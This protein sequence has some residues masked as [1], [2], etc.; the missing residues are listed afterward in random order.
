VYV[1]I[2]ATA[3]VLFLISLTY[4]RQ[5]HE[6]INKYHFIIVAF[7]CMFLL[8]TVFIAI[9]SSRN[10]ESRWVIWNTIASLIFVSTGFLFT[11][12]RWLITLA[13]IVYS[14]LLFSN[15][16]Y[17]RNYNTLIPI[18]S[19]LMFQNLNGLGNS[20]ISSMRIKDIFLL[21][22]FLLLIPSLFIRNPVH[23]KKQRWVIF[24]ST[25]LISSFLGVCDIY[26]HWR[27]RNERFI[28][29]FYF[30]SV[31]SAYSVGFTGYLVW[32][33]VQKS[34]QTN[35]LKPEQDQEIKLFLANHS[36]NTGLKNTFPGNKNIFLIIVESLESWTLGSNIED[37]EITPH[38]NELLTADNALYFPYIVP[39]T[40]GGKSSDCQ[41]M[42]NT[43]LLPIN[44]GS[45]FF[46]Y[47]NSSYYTLAKSLKENHQF[48]TCQTFIGDEASFWNQGLMNGSLGFD[49][50]VSSED[51]DM[52]EQ[53]NMGLSDESFFRQSFIKIKSLEQPF[54]VQMI[55][56]SSHMPFNIPIS[57]THI[58]FS[59]QYPEA[60]SNYV[61]AINYFD[62]SFGQFIDSLKANNLFDNSIIIITGDHEGFLSG[63]G[64][65]I[66][67]ADTRIGKLIT[68]GYFVPLLIINSEMEGR[69][70]KI[71]GQINI[72]P[73]IIDLLGIETPWHGLG[74]SCFCQDFVSCVYRQDYEMIGDTAI[75]EEKKAWY[76]SDLII[77]KNWF[78]QN[79]LR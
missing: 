72:Y 17:Y 14:L 47:P 71:M 73:T 36:H 34:L 55:T 23:H 4:S 10:P 31:E 28:D 35:N 19:Y 70:D 60:F 38:V 6:V 26:Y 69:H 27:S 77:T 49:H 63:Q 12:R 44:S 11:S 59:D 68:T 51:F 65:E 20:I 50:L 45:T 48:K 13:I 40:K 39:Q 58:N 1:F 79:P 15:V 29:A 78:K 2:S 33:I 53:I 75:E 3:S 5:V 24:L 32:Q 7:F 57:K 66:A 18:D 21:M 43:G 42:L 52:T 56:L 22:P 16:L 46:Q 64:K 54:F 74:K 62:F 25:I 9:L 30:D 61:K 37:K 76:I 8:H 67:L 41:L